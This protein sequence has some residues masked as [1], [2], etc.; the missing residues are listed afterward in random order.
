M[1]TDA[2]AVMVSR[3]QASQMFDLHMYI[4][5][6]GDSRFWSQAIIM[7]VAANNTDKLV[8]MFC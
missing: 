3:L 4:Y 7:V 2:V 6:V 8:L 5:E 1:P